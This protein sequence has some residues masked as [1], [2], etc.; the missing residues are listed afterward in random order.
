MSDMNERLKRLDES[1]VPPWFDIGLL[2]EDETIAQLRGAAETLKA[3]EP[4]I[5]QAAIQAYRA[6]A[7]F[8]LATEGEG[9]GD[10]LFS[11]AQKYS[12]AAELEG[13]V[14]RLLTHLSTSL[15][16]AGPMGNF[17]DWAFEERDRLGAR[18]PKTDE[19]KKQQVSP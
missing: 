8:D 9:L 7:R 3:L 18:W 13:V 2:L 4:A 11:L 17:A 12:G 1:G 10:D 5:R 6:Q 15:C 16:E 14:F 19:E